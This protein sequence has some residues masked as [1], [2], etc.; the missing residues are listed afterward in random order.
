MILIQAVDPKSE[1]IKKMTLGRTKCAAIVNGVISSYAFDQILHHIKS[2]K[3]SLLI[4]E[5][6]DTSTIKQLVL[7]A[8]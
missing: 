4:D 2:N 5:T 1:V 8:R 6:T 3:F 7:I